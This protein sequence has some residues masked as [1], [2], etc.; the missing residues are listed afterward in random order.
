MCGHI[1]HKKLLFAFQ[2]YR[3]KGNNWKHGPEKAG[4]EARKIKYFSRKTS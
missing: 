4:K 1:I 2:S 3:V